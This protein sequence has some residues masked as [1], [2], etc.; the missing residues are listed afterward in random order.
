MLFNF[1]LTNPD[2]R[3]A[4]E[5]SAKMLEALARRIRSGEFDVEALKLT[6]EGTLTGQIKKVETLAVE[7]FGEKL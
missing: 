1:H 3:N 2:H 7:N 4:K 5:W 6:M